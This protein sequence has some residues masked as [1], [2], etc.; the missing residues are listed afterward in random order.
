VNGRIEIHHAN[1][2]RALSPVRSFSRAGKDD[3]DDD[4]DDSEI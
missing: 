2:N 4:E 3:D 1:D